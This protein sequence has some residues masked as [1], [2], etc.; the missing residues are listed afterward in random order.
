MAPA[1][2]KIDP[3]AA[4]EAVPVVEQPDLGDDAAIAVVTPLGNIIGPANK[5]PATVAGMP[6]PKITGVFPSG[7]LRED[8]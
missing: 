2:K 5:A 7:N 4:I 3:V 6:V 8:Y 1:T